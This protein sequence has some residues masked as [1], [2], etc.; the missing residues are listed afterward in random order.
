MF[1]SLSLFLL[2]V[3]IRLINLC[4]E[5]DRPTFT[6]IQ[7]EEYAREVESGEQNPTVSSS[8]EGTDKSPGEL[9]PSS[10]DPNRVSRAELDSM[11]LPAFVAGNMIRYRDAGGVYRQ[12]ED[13]RRIYGMD[14]GLFREL[15]PFI[16]LEEGQESAVMYSARTLVNESG[17]PPGTTESHD[18]ITGHSK[19][20]TELHA[21]H[22]E[23]KEFTKSHWKVQHEMAVTPV[24][25]NSAD[26]L[27]LLLLPGIGPVFASR[28]LKYRSLLGGYHHPGQLLEVY[29]MDSA[30]YLGI[31]PLLELDTSH[32]VGLDLNQAGYGELLRHPYLTPEHTR[33]IV[34]WREFCGSIESAE[35]LREQGILGEADF[36]K[37]RPYLA[38]SDTVK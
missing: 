19:G 22:T 29:G 6:R 27:D 32:I 18:G 13:L 17:T 9:Q 34:A 37:V 5:Q 11:G 33:A 12:K 8:L 30:R 1:F 36:L 23:S 28:I 4:H 3:V 7:V 24:E 26:T 10:F 21:R 16:L 20:I 31:V 14:S 35:S 15:L 2:A 25:L 38:V